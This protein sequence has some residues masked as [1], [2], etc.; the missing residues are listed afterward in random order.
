MTTRQEGGRTDVLAQARGFSG[1]AVND[2]AA[3]Q[4]FYT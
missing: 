3:A 1:F 4:S 2:I